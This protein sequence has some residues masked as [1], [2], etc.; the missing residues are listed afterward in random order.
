MLELTDDTFNVCFSINK[1][2]SSV[3]FSSF[4]AFFCEC[5]VAVV[6]EWHQLLLKLVRM[7]RDL[8]PAFQCLQWILSNVRNT[9]LLCTAF[10]VLMGGFVEI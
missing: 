8:F 1:G 10:V 3:L 7:A 4:S 6:G 2:I 9:N 5:Y